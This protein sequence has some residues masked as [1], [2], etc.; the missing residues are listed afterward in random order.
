M[1]FRVLAHEDNIGCIL[2][3][4]TSVADGE[5]EYSNP[6]VRVKCQSKFCKKLLWHFTLTHKSEGIKTQL[7]NDIKTYMQ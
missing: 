2:C 4:L 5:T 7:Q 6:G 1:F 3:Q